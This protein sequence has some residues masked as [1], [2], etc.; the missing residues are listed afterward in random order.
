MCGK[1]IIIKE[2]NKSVQKLSLISL[3]MKCDTK[4]YASSKIAIFEL[5][6]FIYMFRKK[7]KT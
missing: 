3:V 7:V 4:K 6:N 1:V 5:L 2:T